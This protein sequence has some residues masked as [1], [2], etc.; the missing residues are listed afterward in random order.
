[1]MN[2]NINICQIGLFQMSF[3]NRVEVKDQCSV[4]PKTGGQQIC[5][6]ILHHYDY[7]NH[8]DHDHHERTPSWSWRWPGEEPRH[9]QAHEEAPGNGQLGIL[10][11]DMVAVVLQVW[12]SYEHIEWWPSQWSI[13]AIM[14]GCAEHDFQTTALYCY[15]PVLQVSRNIST[16]RSAIFYL[17]RPH[18]YIQSGSNQYHRQ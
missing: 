10:S 4:K 17:W 2:I 11:T 3:F 8:H 14:H 5:Q 12:S 13:V 15:Q 18:I 16:I 7:H 1:M 6:L 9:E